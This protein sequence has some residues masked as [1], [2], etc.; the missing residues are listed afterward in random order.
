MN[1]AKSEIIKNGKVKSFI[2]YLHIIQIVKY[3]DIVDIKIHN[4]KI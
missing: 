3:V 4:L 2:K 1:L